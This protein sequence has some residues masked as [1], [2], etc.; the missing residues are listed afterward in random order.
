MEKYKIL[1]I[2]M[3]ALNILLSI[4]KWKEIVENANENGDNLISAIPLIHQGRNGSGVINLKIYLIVK[5]E[6]VDNFT[7]QEGWVWILKMLDLVK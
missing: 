2:F 3:I 4:G 6:V 7:K 5:A 1:K